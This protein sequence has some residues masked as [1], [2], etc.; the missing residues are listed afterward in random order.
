MLKSTVDLW[1]SRKER[2]CM[3]SDF[4]RGYGEKV[5]AGTEGGKWIKNK[6]VV[7]ENL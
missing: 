5:G 3:T 1:D 6:R 2:H 4:Y 7:A